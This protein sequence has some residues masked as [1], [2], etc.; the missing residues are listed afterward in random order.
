M[1]WGVSSTTTIFGCASMLFHPAAKLALLPYELRKLLDV[2]GLRQVA[3]EAGG[4]EPLT[5]V[6]HGE[7]GERDHAKRRRGRF[8]PQPSQGRDAVHV[9]QLDIHED[10]VRRVLRGER[11]GV[12]R[13]LRFERTVAIELQD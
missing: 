8:G 11:D 1:L 3:V 7:G 13:R 5:V 12:A 4:Q 6:A 9:R 10:E 2:D